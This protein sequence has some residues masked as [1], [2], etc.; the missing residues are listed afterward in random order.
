M[1]AA[2]TCTITLGVSSIEVTRTVAGS[3]SSELFPKV[4]ISGVY[5]TKIN[6]SAN[7]EAATRSMWTYRFAKMI[8]I[9]VVMN[10][11]SVLSFDIQE[12][13]NQATWTADLA[14]QQKCVADINSWLVL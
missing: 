12:V 8:I 13:T 5:P 4:A 3:N 9:D 1:A 10:D 7:M 6:D 14:G 2:S 11:G